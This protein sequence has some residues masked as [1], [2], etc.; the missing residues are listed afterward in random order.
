VSAALA[1]TGANIPN[2]VSDDFVYMD[3]L[4]KAGMLDFADCVG[5]HHNGINLPPTVNYNNA[6]RR[7]NLRF[8]GPWD[9]PHHSWSFKSTLEGYNQRIKAAGKNT[10]LCVTEFGWASVE[11]LKKGKPRSG[12]EFAYD[13]SLQDQAN[14]T[15]QAIK[16]M[17]QWGFVRLAFLWNLN[18]GASS[19]VLDGPTG[20]NIL[21]A[22]IGPEWSKR[23]VWGKLQSFDFRGKPRKASQ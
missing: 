5:A 16:L 19:W 20:D 18:Y 12:F 22:I 9:T 3:Q 14:Y 1:P 15:E 13:N 11:D 6:P 23:P 4:I 7:P 10:K 2:K 8:N 21:Y 17:Q